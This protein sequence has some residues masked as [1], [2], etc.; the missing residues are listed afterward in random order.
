MHP[1]NLGGRWGGASYS[2]NVAYLARSVGG[3]VRA[4]G[5]QPVA[6]EWVFL[7]MFLL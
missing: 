4:G 6:V 2:P 3:G 5:A 7:P 1:P